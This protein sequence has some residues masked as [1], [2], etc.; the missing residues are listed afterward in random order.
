M[1]T[2]LVTQYYDGLAGGILVSHQCTECGTITFPA[3]SCCEKCGSYDYEDRTLSGR[4]TLLFAS[5]NV[6]ACHP[7]FEPYAPYAYGHVR[8]DE[9]VI[10]Q[11]ILQGVDG[12]AAAIAELYPKLPLPVRAEVLHTADLPVLTFRLA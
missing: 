3:T 10:V 6:A 8:L 1:T 11:G 4:G 7:R 12:T 5:H 2:S 9:G